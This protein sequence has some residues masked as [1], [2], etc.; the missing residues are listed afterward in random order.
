MSSTWHSCNNGNCVE[1]A[2][3]GDTVLV[4]DG[5]DADG[6]VLTFSRTEWLS[7]REGIKAGAFDAV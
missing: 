3:H 7:F 1:V 2:R 5:K 6:P 4:R